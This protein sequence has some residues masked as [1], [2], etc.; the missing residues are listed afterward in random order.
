[1][2][3][4]KRTMV[5]NPGAMKKAKKGRKKRAASNHDAATANIL[6]MMSHAMG[7]DCLDA[8]VR[9]GR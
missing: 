7:F 8:W 3:S 4:A 6:N 5:H 2:I 9:F 1:M